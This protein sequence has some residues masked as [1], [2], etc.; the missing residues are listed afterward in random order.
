[1]LMPEMNGGKAELPKQLRP[2]PLYGVLF[3]LIS[4]YVVIIC[5][6]S[7]ALGPLSLFLCAILVLV[8]MAIGTS[9]DSS[10]TRSYPSMTYLMLISICTV[11]HAFYQGIHIYVK[12]YVPYYYATSG[13]KYTG[14]SLTARPGRYADAGVMEFNNDAALD[15]SRSFGLKSYD[16][17]Y[18]VAPIISK[19]ATMHPHSLGQKITFW[20]I[21]RDCC[22][23]RGNFECDGADDL[24]VRSGFVAHDAVEDIENFGMAP[25]R[26]IVTDFLT[27]QT[28]RPKYIKAIQSA[29]VLH[30]L[31]CDF[32]EDQLIL[33]RW[34]AKPEDILETW[35]VRAILACVISCVV[36]AVCVTVLWIAI[37]VYVDK[38]VRTHYGPLVRGRPS[39]SEQT[40]DSKRSNKDPF[41]LNQGGA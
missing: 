17:T 23:N 33:L 41:M 30:D 27:P 35:H 32:E 21:G 10:W 25:G 38:E 13:E 34:A 9:E 14:V 37:H 20:A 39:P 8:M 5:T 40:S 19:E 6:L 24:E 4:T 7:F 28:D 1:M 16:Y 31:R 11:A 36:Y 3:S 15:G 22:S 26:N 29:C 18:C 12:H 2:P